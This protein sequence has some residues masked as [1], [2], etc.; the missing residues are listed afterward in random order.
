M[1]IFKNK[2]II[3]RLVKYNL[4]LIGIILISTNCSYFDYVLAIAQEA[5]E[6]ET[7]YKLF[8]YQLEFEGRVVKKTLL[9]DK[10]SCLIKLNKTNTKDVFEKWDQSRKTYNGFQTL[11]HNSHYQFLTKADSVFIR[12]RTNE[13]FNE[14]YVEN[15]YL[16]FNLNK[17]IYDI[18]REND[19]I[20]KRE[21]HFNLIIN[22]VEYE[23]KYTYNP[24]F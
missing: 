1:N 15:L 11:F 14:F 17:N 18:I 5:K 19:T 10:L 23:H 3:F 9:H 13:I 4:L 16:E 12:A 7:S 21:N 2:R 8:Y 20:L 24:W 6:I 22:S